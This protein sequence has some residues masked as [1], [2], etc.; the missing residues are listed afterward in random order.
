MRK[1][2]RQ[3]KAPRSKQDDWTRRF[4]R[5]TVTLSQ[6]RTAEPLGWSLMQELIK[7]FIRQNPE[8]V[9]SSAREGIA[10]ERL[11]E[12]AEQMIDLGLLRIVHHGPYFRVYVWN[13]QRS[14]YE[15]A[16]N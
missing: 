6:M 14:R 1:R 13:P 9:R 8:W 16:G 2:H 3:G 15:P 7:T 5:P 10:G 4:T 12:L 11:H